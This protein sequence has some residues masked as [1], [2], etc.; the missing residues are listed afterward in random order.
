MS[1][2]MVLVL[3]ILVVGFVFAML[4]KKSNTPAGTGGGA[5]TGASGGGGRH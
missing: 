2:T 3:A 4:N 1:K 5:Q